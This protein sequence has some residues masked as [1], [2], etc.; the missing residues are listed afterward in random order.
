MKT[1]TIVILILSQLVAAAG[2]AFAVLTALFMNDSVQS[3]QAAGGAQAT[4]LL[5]MAPV[6]LVV[7]SM[8]A[9]VAAYF[10]R[11]AVAL[12][13][14]LVPFVFGAFALMNTSTR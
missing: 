10:K 11:D 13:L 6:V 2:S 1:S 4:R 12:A 5:L 9:W 7:C 14:M 8:A 3:A